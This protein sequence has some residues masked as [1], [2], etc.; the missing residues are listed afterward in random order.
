MGRFGA[1]LVSAVDLRGAGR[2]TG[3]GTRSLPIRTVP[4]PQSASTFRESGCPT[5]LSAN[6]TSSGKSSFS[7][8][9]VLPARCVSSV[10]ARSAFDA[11]IAQLAPCLPL[12][13]PA[14][15]RAPGG[16]SP[17]WGFLRPAWWLPGAGHRPVRIPLLCL[18]SPEGR[19][20]RTTQTVTPALLVLI[21]AGGFTPGA[22]V[23]P[24]A[25][26]A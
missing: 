7:F 22:L 13:P 14:P 18:S 12:P 10:V 20:C 17:C 3:K 2:G 4:C 21:W 11:I 9:S 16:R 1:A 5:R 6:V 26:L 25:K 8:S 23:S 24:S 15:L 19:S